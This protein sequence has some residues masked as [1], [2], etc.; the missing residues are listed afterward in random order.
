MVVFWWLQTGAVGLACVLAATAMAQ[1]E[2]SLSDMPP[3]D[4]YDQCIGLTDGDPERAFEAA[5]A[6]R[7]L[8]GGLP[9]RHCVA[10]ALVAL[11]SYEAAATR[12]EELAD[13]MKGFPAAS[14]AEVL[15]QAGRAWFL[16]KDAQRAYAAVTAGLQTAPDNVELLIDRGEI[17]AVAQSYWDALDDFNRALELSPA[18]IDALIFR[19]AAYRLVDAAEL[20]V[21]D[22]DKALALAPDH[23]EALIER[24]MLRR[25]GGDADGAREDWLHVIRVAPGSR[26]AEIAQANIERLDGGGR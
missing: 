20:A 24:G 17:L 18:R 3:A 13:D 10:L 21:E 4:A 2:P 25:L 19:A 14:R 15:A 1:D 9:A 16:A 6:W 12:L 26:A 7:D 22:I 23:P 5:L 8:D 11:E